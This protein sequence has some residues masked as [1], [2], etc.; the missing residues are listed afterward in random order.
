MTTRKSV[1]L[2]HRMLAGTAILG[3]LSNQANLKGVPSV[4]EPLHV[5]L[6]NGAIRALVPVGNK[7]QFG[8]LPEE[9]VEKLAIIFYG[10]IDR[11]VMKAIEV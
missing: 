5:A 2:G 3:D 10:D 8:N 7:S 9:V 11:A 4:A 6:E 1:L